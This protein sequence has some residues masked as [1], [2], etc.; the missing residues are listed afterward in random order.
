MGDREGLQGG[1]RRGPRVAMMRMPERSIRACFLLLTVCL[2]LVL[3]SCAEDATGALLAPVPEHYA[4][5]TA[6]D[7]LSQKTDGS[8]RPADGLAACIALAVAEG[9]R[10]EDRGTSGAETWR[11]VTDDV[12]RCRDRWD[13]TQRGT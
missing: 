7:V 8:S 5:L 1:V 2:A 9:E 10:L 3:S 12:A 6:R 13:S 11:S 4:S